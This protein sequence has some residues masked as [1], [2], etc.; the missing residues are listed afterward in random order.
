MTE[1][2]ISALARRLEA[3]HTRIGAAERAAAVAVRLAA[4]EERITAAEQVCSLCL[5]RRLIGGVYE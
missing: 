2:K 5:Q 3:L 4:L 1:E